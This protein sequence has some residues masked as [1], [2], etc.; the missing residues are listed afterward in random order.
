MQF[1]IAV[2]D[3]NALADQEVTAIYTR[4]SWP[5][6]GSTSSIQKELDKRY[7]KKT[8]DVHPL[9]ALALIWVDDFLVGWVG[10]RPWPEKFKGKPVTAQT[11]ECFVDFDYRRRGLAKMGLLALIAAKKINRNEIVSVYDSSVVPLAQQCGCT[12]VIYCQP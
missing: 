5:D 3:I 6:S 2:K 10:S 9:M 11:V 4:L 7:L 8:N 12:T 1:N